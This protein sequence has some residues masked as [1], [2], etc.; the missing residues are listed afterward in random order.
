MTGRLRQKQDQG[1][2]LL[3]TLMMFHLNLIHIQI[4]V[5]FL[6][7]HPENTQCLAPVI[8]SSHLEN[9]QPL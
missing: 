3:M 5:H 7:R 2:T 1:W 9:R 4:R 6:V 8:P